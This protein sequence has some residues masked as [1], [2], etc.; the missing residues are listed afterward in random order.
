MSYD[1]VAKVILLG[2]H[3]AGKSSLLS[4]LTDRNRPLTTEATIGVDFGA[5]TI[6]DGK[7]RNIRLQIWDTAGQDQFQSIVT[8]YYRQIC[9][10]VVVIDLSDRDSLKVASE[11][12]ERLA[13]HAPKRIPIVLVA[14]KSDI[15][16]GERVVRDA[17]LAKFGLQEGNLAWFLASAKDGSNVEAPFRRLVEEIGTNFIDAEVGCPGLRDYGHDRTLR[18]RSFGGT[19][20][21]EPSS[22]RCCRTS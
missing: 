1:Y 2:K 5:V 8:A 4:K 16:V 20:T 10:A 22:R 14:N 13:H 18:L 7:D 9:G 11:A 12:L 19:R 21:P 6:R 15:P 17:D 3:N